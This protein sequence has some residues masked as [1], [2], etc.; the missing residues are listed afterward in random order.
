MV[1]TK[2]EVLERE[3]SEG[4][5]RRNVQK[6]HCCSRYKECPGTWYQTHRVVG[7]ARNTRHLHQPH[8][9]TKTRQITNQAAQATVRS[10]RHRQHKLK[11]EFCSTRMFELKLIPP[12][13]NR[14]Q[15]WERMFLSSLRRLCCRRRLRKFSSGRLRRPSEL[16]N[17]KTRDVPPQAKH[18]RSEDSQMDVLSMTVAGVS[19]CGTEDEDPAES[20]DGHEVAGECLDPLVDP[21]GTEEA[22][23]AKLE[24]TPPTRRVALGKKRVTT[25]WDQDGIIARFV[26]REFKGDETVYDMFAPSSTPSTGRVI[27]NF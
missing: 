5:N 12:E 17:P 7:D 15:R 2:N 19:M 24:R 9:S 8:Q 23:K 21:A 10:R 11:V 18:P 13:V 22:T 26:A 27:D 20:F 1:G 4:W 25:R 16:L 14:R 3:Q 6:L